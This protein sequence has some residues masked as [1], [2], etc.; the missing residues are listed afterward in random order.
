MA[1]LDR[2]SRPVPVDMLGRERSVSRVVTSRAVP[3]RTDPLLR[4]E[5]W[6][7]VAQGINAR[8]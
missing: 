8:G 2:G 5:S 7:L 6:I 1:G 4:T 3:V